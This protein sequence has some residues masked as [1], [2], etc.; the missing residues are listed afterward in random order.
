V[1]DPV[2][3]TSTPMLRALLFDLDDTLVEGHNSH[4]AAMEAACAQTADAHPEQTV[5]GLRRAFAALYQ[6]LEPYLHAGVA[7]FG[8]E[9]REALNEAIPA[10]K[11]TRE[12][13]EELGQRY[14]WE[15]RERYALFPEVPGVLSELAKH[16]RLVVVTNGPGTIQRE[17]IAALGLDRWI[18]HFAIS[19]EVG[20]AKPDSLIFERALQLAEARPAEAM[21][22]GDCLER[23][24]AGAAALGIQTAWLRRDLPLERSAGIAADYTLSDLTPL[25]TL[26]LWPSCTELAS[27]A[28]ELFVQ[29]R[30]SK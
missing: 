10:C 11:L 15:R 22:V 13:A 5:E 21:M 25:L 30:T 14:L 27:G 24:V 18:T 23:D 1:K 28:T 4:R 26:V 9:T 8:P 16:L 20:S 3:L 6:R 17:K 29:L 12:L 7:T 2:P 19:G